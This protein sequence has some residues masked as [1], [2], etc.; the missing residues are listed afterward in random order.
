MGQFRAYQILAATE[1]PCSALDEK[2]ERAYLARGKE[3]DEAVGALYE[4]RPCPPEL[5]HWERVAQRVL[6][7]LPRGGSWQGKLFY[8]NEEINLVEAHPDCL[9][10]PEQA[11]L[12][13]GKCGFSDLKT[14][15]LPT[16]YTAE[17]Y[18]YSLQMATYAHY[19]LVQF[20]MLPETI[21]IVLSSTHFE[22]PP[23]AYNKDGSISMSQECGKF[24]LQ[25]A[26]D[27]F[28]RETEDKIAAGTKKGDKWDREKYEALVGKTPL[29]QPII[30]AE[31]GPTEIQ[32]V[33][34]IGRIYAEFG[35]QI[36]Q[37][38]GQSIVTR[39]YKGDNLI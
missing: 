3:I 2:F 39:P 35:L 7:H 20:G 12:A 37:S 30:V 6:A 15:P 24:R 36:L 33:A 29:W 27:A 8:P 34:D 22:E 13:K 1:E 25:E 26:V 4:G 32:A 28:I 17:C 23:V 5:G 14:T 16:P 11:L 10:T 9:V 21:R 18:A 31:L 38:P 19:F